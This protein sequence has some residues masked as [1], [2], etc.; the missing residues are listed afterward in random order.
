MIHEIVRPCKWWT[1]PKN[2]PHVFKVLEF[3]DFVGYPFVKDIVSHIVST[4]EDDLFDMLWSYRRESEAESIMRAAFSLNPTS[5]CFSMLSDALVKRTRTVVTYALKNDMRASDMV[6][7]HYRWCLI[8]AKLFRLP[9]TTALSYGMNHRL[10]EFSDTIGRMIESRPDDA[11]LSS[12]F[13]PI[14]PEFHQYCMKRYK[15]ISPPMA[16]RKLL[17]SEKTYLELMNGEHPD[18]WHQDLNL[19][20]REDFATGH[21]HFATLLNNIDEKKSTF[22]HSLV[23]AKI[24]ISSQEFISVTL[25]PDARNLTFRAHHVFYQLLPPSAPKSLTGRLFLGILY[26]D[27]IGLMR[28]AGTF[29]MLFQDTPPMPCESVWFSG[30]NSGRNSGRA[31]LIRVFARRSSHRGSC[32]RR[33]LAAQPHR[34]RVRQPGGAQTRSGGPRDLF[35]GRRGGGADGR[36]ARYPGPRDGRRDRGRRRG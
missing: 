31:V 29:S 25:S 1:P 16:P 12:F 35:F 13:H 11:F 34:H 7:F 9:T 30:R 21:F 26:K 4:V 8:D 28:D 6:V 27:D 18:M 32:R 10:P 3:A 19:S 17:F 5:S 15:K 2:L 20:Y 36:G 24:P 23:I 22:I 14:V 33:P